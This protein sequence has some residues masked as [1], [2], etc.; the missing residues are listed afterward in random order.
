MRQFA[1]LPVLVL[2]AVIACNDHR[3]YREPTAPMEPE[4]PAVQA[5]VE[6]DGTEDVDATASP[7][8]TICTVY[9]K[10]L[11]RAKSRFGQNP[12]MAV[13]REEVEALEALTADVCS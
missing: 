5:A 3:E 9:S 12:G 11:D 7:R 4:V 13:F 8:S 2:V 10:E 6:T 1:L